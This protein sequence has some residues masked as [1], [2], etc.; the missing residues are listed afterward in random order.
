MPQLLLLHGF[1]GAPS[2]W[3]RVVCA[4]DGDFDVYRPWL[5][6][7]G[8][9]DALWDACRD[10][11]KVAEAN[12]S[13]SDEARFSGY[14]SE[15][16]RLAAHAHNAGFHQGLIA[17]YSLGARLALG[18][19]IRYPQRFTHALFIS[20]Q[21]GLTSDHE[22]A[23]R[24]S[25]DARWIELLQNAPLE[26]VVERWQAQPLFET[27][28][29]LPDALLSEQRAVRLQHTRGGLARSLRL[30]GLGAMPNLRPVLPTCPEGS[31]VV[32]GELD[33]KF[34][35]LGT[36]LAELLPNA[37][38]HIVPGRGHNLPLE[39]PQSLARLINEHVRACTP[40]S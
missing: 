29:G 34:V 12:Q 26:S 7:H 5:G 8:P 23:L 17:G 24:L 6:G 36:E 27:Q 11:P 30:T 3:D 33:Q 13:A 1:M 31:S 15:V 19:C 32:V 20:G 4:L 21:P 37:N 35:T 18:L 2:T 22:R 38:L 40:R 39:S 28:L 16:D 9:R 10:E 14:W 25:Q